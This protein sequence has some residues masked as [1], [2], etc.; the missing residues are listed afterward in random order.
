MNSTAKIGEIC[1]QRSDIAA[2]IDGELPPREELELEMHLEVCRHCSDELNEQKKF[3]LALGH[4][5]ET[6]TPIE[7]PENFTRIVVANAESKVSGLRR[8]QER[9]KALF[10]C[11]SLFLLVVLGL[12]RETKATFEAFGKFAEQFLAVGGFVWNLV[13]DAAFATAI[14]LRS[15]S[16]QVAN[17]SSVSLTIL[18]G[19]VFILLAV[20]SRIIIRLHRA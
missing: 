7:L 8:P 9:A 1:S 10:A 6:E 17:N 11:A 3:L 18:L 19:L 16:H 14:I 20:F 4:A 5:L 13:Y 12:G 15:L 2:Y